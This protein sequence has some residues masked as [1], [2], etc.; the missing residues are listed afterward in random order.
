MKTR[1]ILILLVIS[2]AVAGPAGG[3]IF[4]VL[5]CDD[6]GWNMLGRLFVGCV[7]A[8]LTPLSGGFPPQNEG[9]VGPPFNAWP[10]IVAAGILTFGFLVYRECR[11]TQRE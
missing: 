4:G 2:L 7:M 11:K 9:G 3:F 5:N 8:V 10:H 6:C 1:R